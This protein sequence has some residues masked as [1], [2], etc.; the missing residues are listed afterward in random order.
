MEVLY[1]SITSLYNKIHRHAFLNHPDGH[2]YFSEIDELLTQKENFIAFINREYSFSIFYNVF[3]SVS[4]FYYAYRNQ[5]LLISID[6]I[7]Y[8][9]LITVSS[10]KMLEVLPKVII[11]MQTKRISEQITS[12]T[13]DD[14]I[15]AR[16]L[17]YMTRSNIYYYNTFLTYYNFA[18]YLLYFFL[19]KGNYANHINRT[20]ENISSNNNSIEVTDKTIN[21][22]EFQNQD[23]TNF[24][25]ILKLLCLGYFFKLIVSFIN[26]L[27]YFKYD[28]NEADIQNSSLYMDYSTRASNE[29]INMIGS[30]VIDKQNIRKFTNNEEHAEDSGNDE[31]PDNKS[32]CIC[33]LYFKMNDEVRILPCNDNHIFHKDCIDK[34]LKQNKNCPTCR[35]EINKL[36]F[37]TK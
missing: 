34:W 4:S 27:F 31:H 3:I 26:Y 17:M 11:L 13:T 36:M 6:L 2:A 25:L 19:S 18:F 32:C 24:Y 35:K 29:L 14:I 30:Q 7:A 33:I 15:C 16:R 10:I 22:M 12:Q 20:F 1:K 9:W 8:V 37:K 21:N 23:I 28:V 5:S